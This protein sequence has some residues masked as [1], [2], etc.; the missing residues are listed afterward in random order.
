[1]SA[2]RVSRAGVDLCRELYPVVCLDAYQRAAVGV[3]MHEAVVH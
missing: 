3:V 1:M 2:T